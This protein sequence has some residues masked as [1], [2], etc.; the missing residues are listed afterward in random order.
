MAMTR[1]LTRPCLQR[2]HEEHRIS[3]PCATVSSTP[4]FR[5]LSCPPNGW[6]MMEPAAQQTQSF[7]LMIPLIPLL[8]QFSFYRRLKCQATSSRHSSWFTKPSPA[9]MHISFL[10]LIRLGISGVVS[11]CS[12]RI[13]QVETLETKR[14]SP[15]ASCTF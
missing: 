4:S 6:N 11:G 15:S 8:G 12:Q 10:C 3:S 5:R 1:L 9:Q 14:W 2:S 13:H 7:W